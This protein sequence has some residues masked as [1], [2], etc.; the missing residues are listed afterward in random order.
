M[1]YYLS[2][3]LPPLVYPLG[4]A[5]LLIIL[6]L[7]L[8][9]R[10]RRWTTVVLV[11]ALALLWLGGN[12][13]VMM[14]VVSSLEWRYTPPAELS[15]LDVIVVLGGGSKSPAPPRAT[16]EVGEAGD[17]MIYAASLYQQGVAPRLILSGG[18]VMVDGTAIYPEANAMAELLAILGV[19]ADALI[20][21][22]RSRNTYENA[23][24]VKRELA[25]LRVERIG[26]V[27]SALHMPRS[28]AIFARQGISV[29][30]LPTDY[31]VTY[32]DWDF[33]TQPNLAVQLANLAP[34]AGNLDKVSDA[35]KEYIGIAVYWLRG[36]L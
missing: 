18:G 16:A 25:A 35:L 9:W 23:V 17:R 31:Q 28:V 8:L 13:I 1:F 27:T 10:S 15:E 36:W 30:P 29:T 12:R 32:A 6:A 7:F 4:A 5:S 20:L 34:T 11:A 26:L 21:E 14:T 19:P 3:A 22:S 33:Y 24:E 2:K